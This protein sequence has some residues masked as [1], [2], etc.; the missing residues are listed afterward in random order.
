MELQ[1]N[2]YKE[3]W[4]QVIRKVSVTSRRIQDGFPHAS[5]DGTYRLE[6]ASWWTAG[7][8]PGLLWLIYRDTQIERKGFGSLRSHARN[9]LIR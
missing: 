5:V 2:W 1:E 7:F 9:S 4:E 8:W 6:P 3:A